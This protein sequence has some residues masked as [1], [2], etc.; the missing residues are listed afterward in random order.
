M[1]LKLYNY[2]RS[3]PSYRV[4]IA[5]HLKGLEFKYIPIHLLNN[6]GEQHGAE[7]QKINPAQEVPALWHEGAVIS[8]SVAIIEYL[9]EAFP[10][11]P[12]YPKQP[13]QRARVRQLCEIIN[14]THPLQNL[15]VLQFLEKDLGF[16]EPQKNQWIS[17]WLHRGFQTYE[18]TVRVTAGL[19]SVG[20]QVTAADLF[21]VPQI[22]SAKRFN[23]DTSGYKLITRIGEACAN[24]EAFQKA[25]PTRQID[26]PPELRVD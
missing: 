5:L 19:F 17:E 22:L 14:C 6:G 21:L 7:Y 10:N 13:H 11:P 25:H 20:D 2:F 23:I 12:L 9:D 18:E 8:Q 3:S 24:L 26:T 16:K 15:K 1:E 4:R